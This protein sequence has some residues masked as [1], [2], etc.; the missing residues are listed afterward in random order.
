[1]EHDFIYQ[2]S[3]SVIYVGNDGNIFY[4]GHGF[5]LM[6]AKI[7]LYPHLWLY[8]VLNYGFAEYRKSIVCEN[9]GESL[10]LE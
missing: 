3:F 2:C 5:K 6:S 10:I 8:K 4:I 9:E 7:V 1:M